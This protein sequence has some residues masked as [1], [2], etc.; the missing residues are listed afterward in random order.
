[1]RLVLLPGLD[2]TGELFQSF[3]K[4]L[5]SSLTPQV[6]SYPTNQYLTYKELVP[7]VQKVLPSRESFVLLGESF[8]GPLSIEI[9][10]LHPANLRAVIL[11]ASFISNPV[12]PSLTWVAWLP[13]PLISLIGNLN[14]P[15]IFVQFFAAGM[16][17]PKDLLKLF[18][19]VKQK[20]NPRVI[21][22]R[23][24]AVQE[25]DAREALKKCSIPILY[26]MT[27]QDRLVSSKCFDDIRNIKPNIQ[28]VEL[29]APHFLLQ[30][31]PQEASVA[32]DRFIEGLSGNEPTL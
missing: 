16:D 3:L 13:R 12:P 29:N 21:A 20:V 28:V 19:R 17:S 11:C 1:M 9:A 23:V 24:R 32:V 14:P 8:S 10:A 5:P 15:D 22:Q 25:V 26:L 18:R 30:R 6:V 31:K 4:V 7:F 2:G 27:K